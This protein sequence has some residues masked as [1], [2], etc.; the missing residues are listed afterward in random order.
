MK[1]TTSLGF[2]VTH[3]SPNLGQ[4]TWPM[5][6]KMILADYRVKLNKSKKKDKYLDLARDLKIHEIDGDSDWN[7]CT[8]Y[9]HQRN[10]KGSGELG[11]KRMGGNH[12]NSSIIKISQNTEKSHGNLR[13]LA[14]T[15][16]PVRNHQLTLM[17]KIFKRVKWK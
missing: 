6:L 8:R 9:R 5:I 4:A 7:W 2:W 1:C 3:G 14:V 16:N 13:R 11:N 15:R 12:S 10:D 17:W